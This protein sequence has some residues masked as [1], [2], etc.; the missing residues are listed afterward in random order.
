MLPQLEKSHVPRNDIVF[1]SCPRSIGYPDSE[2]KP[3][4]TYRP[5]CPESSGET[6]KRSR[7][8]VNIRVHV[9]RMP[10]SEIKP[11]SAVVET[12]AEM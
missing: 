1:F 2:G 3:H 5:T 8:L 10:P 4:H 9:V 11:G 12:P 6:R 7:I